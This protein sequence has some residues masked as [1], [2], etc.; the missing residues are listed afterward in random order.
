[1]TMHSSA[2]YRRIVLAADAAALTLMT[3]FRT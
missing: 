2:N 3:F 1:M